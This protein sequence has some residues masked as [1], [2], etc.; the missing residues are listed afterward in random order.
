MKLSTKWLLFSI[1]IGVGGAICVSINQLFVGGGWL[2]L[3]GFSL[4]TAA[5]RFSEETKKAE[6]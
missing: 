5:R 3:S 6:P 4:S 1:G 2:F